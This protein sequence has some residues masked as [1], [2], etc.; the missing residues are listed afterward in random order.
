MVLVLLCS[1]L[2]VVTSLASLNEEKGADCS[3]CFVFLISCYVALHLGAMCL[4]AVCD[5]GVS[6]SY[7]RFA[8]QI[9]SLHWLMKNVRI[10]KL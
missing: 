3:A 6:R 2:S 7:L 8:I 4:S 5:C 9:F 1:A 10:F